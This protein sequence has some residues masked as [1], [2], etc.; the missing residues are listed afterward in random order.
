MAA[1]LRAA[2]PT[3]CTTRPPIS[4]VGPVASAASRVPRVNRPA[5]MVKRR[6]RPKRSDARP[7][8]R[9]RPA[10]DEHVGVD[11]PRHRGRCEPEVGLDGRQRDVDDGG[12]EHDQELG[13]HEQRQ[14]QRLP[15]TVQEPVARLGGGGGCLGAEGRGVHECHA[16]RREA[17]QD[18]ADPRDAHRAAS[19][20]V[21]ASDDVHVLSAPAQVMPCVGGRP[22]GPCRRAR[23][24]SDGC[25]GGR[26]HGGPGRRG[27]RGPLGPEAA[28]HGS[29]RLVLIV[30]VG[31][32]MPSRCR[33]PGFLE[34]VEW[35]GLR[36]AG[37]AGSATCSVVHVADGAGDAL[38][39]H[40]PQGVHGDGHRR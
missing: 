16:S 35:P 24:A 3:P 23:D 39:G 7:E 32:L 8:R 29:H 31:G 22:P 18:G 34:P 20:A 25:A 30:V 10:K 38:C 9:S 4:M 1:G 27:C 28:V 26:H 19:G 2:A 5:P 17:G 21:V 12:V 6:R 37:L 40:P 33:G 13:R 36:L 14:R 15:V 11:H